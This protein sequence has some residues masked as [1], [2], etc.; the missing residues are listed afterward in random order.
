MNMIVVA[1][2]PQVETVEVAGQQLVVADRTQV[3]LVS[4]ANDGRGVRSG[5]GAPSSA[6][7]LEG[8]FY[9]NTLAHT[10]YGPKVGGV[11]GSPTSMVAAGITLTGDVLGS[12]SDTVE[13]TIADGA[14]TLA[15]IAPIATASFMGRNM[16]GSGSPEELTVAT[17]KTMLDLSGSNTGDQTLSGLGA[18][19]SARVIATSS[20]LAGG[21]DLSADRTLSLDMSVANSWTGRQS[22]ATARISGNA[23]QA[24]WGAGGIGFASLA[25][26]YTDS[27]SS[28]TVSAN[29]V[30]ALAAPTLA[31]SS[32]TTYSNAA[33]FY[34]A[35]AP[36]AGS[37]VTLTRPWSMYVAAGNGYL[38]GMLGIG[39]TSLVTASRLTL[40][41]NITGSSVGEVQRVSGTFQSDVTDT[42]Y[43]V[44][45]SLSTQAAS[46][47]LPDMRH[48]LAQ[49]GTIGS[50]STVTRQ[51]AFYASSNLTG[52]GSNYGF[53]GAI[54]AAS[55]RWNLYMAGTA[56]NYVAG[57]MLVGS[58][59]ASIAK[60][61]VVG[62]VTTEVTHAIRAV[63][64][65]TADLQQWQAS[66]GTPVLSIDVSG[67][68]VSTTTGTKIATATTQKIAFHNATPVAQRAGSAQAAVATTAATNSAPYG[69]S[70]AAQADALVALVNELRAAL[71]EKGLIK[72]SA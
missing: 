21:G 9:I 50:G 71:V 16:A 65:Q 59:S 12:G 42:G 3:Q 48:F 19:A 69:F 15:K 66:G 1:A 63:A 53:Y 6:V 29:M 8:D 70:T 10:I 68:I 18:A 26:T 58:T 38:G 54:P 51:V 72:G 11:W 31:A 43:G 4:I 25:A 64:S 22:F 17:A 27:S 5:E 14:V 23:T 46:F 56:D 49:E 37:N 41:G 2:D 55:N 34:I 52:A 13:A 35:S 39:T 32:A 44:R 40:G 30:H 28:G 24:A 36:S 61:V 20:P 62:S 33:T 45:S 7:G 60:S 47:T 57:R 67:N